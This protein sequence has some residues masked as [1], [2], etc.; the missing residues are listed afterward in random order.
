ML[1]KNILSFAYSPLEEF[2]VMAFARNT[3]ERDHAS[4]SSTAK[5]R[6]LPFTRYCGGDSLIVPFKNETKLEPRVKADQ[7]VAK[8][9]ARL[10]KTVE[11][12]GSSDW[13]RQGSKQTD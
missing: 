1:A 13:R 8:G 7:I 5:L 10:E 11:E 12:P 4:A 3:L 9:G 6:T 2:A